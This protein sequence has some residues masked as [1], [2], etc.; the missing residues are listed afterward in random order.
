MF[1]PGIEPG[2]FRVLGGCDNHYT[3]ETEVQENKSPTTY[4]LCVLDCLKGEIQWP[5]VRLPSIAQLVER[6]TVVGSTCRNP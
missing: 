2:T 1:P 6:W 3:T 5:V 4:T